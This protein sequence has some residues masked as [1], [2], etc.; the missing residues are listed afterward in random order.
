MEYHACP[1]SNLTFGQLL[2][3]KVFSALDKCD[4]ITKKKKKKKY[5]ICFALRLI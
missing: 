2:Q 4:F 5:I 3:R 1:V